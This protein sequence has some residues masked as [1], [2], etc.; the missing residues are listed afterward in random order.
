MEVR[1]LR[2]EDWPEVARI[3]GEGIR[4]GDAT[5]ETEVPPWEAWDVGHLERHRLVAERD[6]AVLG[7]AALSP[8]SERCC[9]TGVAEVSVYVAPE[10]QGRRVG[11][12]LLE[13]LAADSE[14][15]GIWTLQ[16]GIFPEN[17]ASVALHQRCGFAVVGRRER[18]GRLNG[19]WRDVLLPER[20][21]ASA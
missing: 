12:A 15:D 11:R 2:D 17:L 14:A 8:V 9:Y 4:T 10:A 1:D 5:F 6:G 3:Y 21:S 16:A 7:W 18:L 19:E 13:R 20:R